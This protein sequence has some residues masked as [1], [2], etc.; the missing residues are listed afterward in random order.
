VRNLLIRNILLKYIAVSKEWEEDEECMG[1]MSGLCRWTQIAVGY[2]GGKIGHSNGG[3]I[4]AWGLRSVEESVKDFRTRRII[5]KSKFCLLLSKY[6]GLVNLTLDRCH[7]NNTPVRIFRL[8]DNLAEE[9]RE[10][11][12]SLHQIISSS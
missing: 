8:A 10:F 6:W 2:S 7:L 1:M 12:G 11:L 4:G 5:P 9:K 3:D